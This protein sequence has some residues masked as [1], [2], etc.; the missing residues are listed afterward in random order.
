MRKLGY[1][2]ILAILL[3][4]GACQNHAYVPSD[5]YSIMLIPGE[6]SGERIGELTNEKGDYTFPDEKP[7]VAP[8]GKCFLGWSLDGE[9]KIYFTGEQIQVDKP[10]TIIAQWEKEIKLSFTAGLGT[11]KSYVVSVARG[12]HY[13]L[14]GLS[15]DISFAPPTGSP[16]GVHFIGW[17]LL[18]ASGV[19][20]GKLIEAG[21]S[22]KVDKDLSYA[23]QWSRSYFIVIDKDGD[24][25][26]D[27]K[28]SVPDGGKYTTPG[29]PP[30][31]DMPD[32]KSFGGWEITDGDGTRIVDPHTPIVITSSTTLKPKWEDL[33]TISFEA[34]EGQG[35]SKSFEL[36]RGSSYRIID[37]PADFEAPYESGLIGVRVFLGW[38]LVSASDENVVISQ[39]VSAQSSL[40]GIEQNIR[41]IA[42]WSPVYTLRYETGDADAIAPQRIVASASFEI[43]NEPTG[44]SKPFAYWS[45]DQKDNKLKLKKGDRVSIT[46][47]MTL[48]AVYEENKLKVTYLP[49]EGS[50]TMPPQ[51]A[52]PGTEINLL[53]SAFAAPTDV[54]GRKFLGWKIGDTDTIMQPGEKLRID[55]EISL[56][57]TWTPVYTISFKSG[58]CGDGYKHMSEYG[59]RVFKLLSGMAFTLP[60]HEDGNPA[61]CQHYY[62]FGLLIENKRTGEFDWGS[63]GEIIV[64]TDNLIITPRYLI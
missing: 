63:A 20:V 39:L 10:T 23:A 43:V 61:S 15:K 33:L 40:G 9:E 32:N 59:T 7:F 11:G 24:G 53:G 12:S 30:A 18:D 13:N 62:D 1:F 28:I 52:N 25:I 50:G 29:T 16:K 51:W 36:I 57:A 54:E 8:E 41:A 22:I 34:G 46:A 6:G 48:T 49:S 42:L 14:P 5:G 35:E 27:E 17:K 64:V 55:A 4:V 26:Q 58:K 47:D 37:C 45:V 56:T 31:G 2:A 21:H 3:F 19:P 60:A 44:S 38:K